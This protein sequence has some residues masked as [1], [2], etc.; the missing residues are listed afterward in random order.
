[1]SERKSAKTAAANNPSQA[2]LSPPP[3]SPQ[4]ESAHIDKLVSLTYDSNPDVRRRAALELSKIDDPRAVFALL[5]LGADKDP[6]VQDLARSSLNSFKGEE[7]ETLISL[8]KIFEAR[9][10]GRVPSEDM[11]AAKQ[12]LMPSLEKYFFSKHKGVREKLMPSLEKIFSWMPPESKGG[13][14]QISAAPAQQIPPLPPISSSKSHSHTSRQGFVDVATA[15]LSEEEKEDARSEEAASMRGQMPMRASPSGEDDD[16]SDESSDAVPASVPMEHT[17]ARDPLAGVDSIRSHSKRVLE[18]AEADVGVPAHLR[19]AEDLRRM[20]SGG[21]AN[22]SI[23]PSS[24]AM[25]QRME[26]ATNFPVPEYLQPKAPS[27]TAAIPSMVDEEKV[28]E[29]LSDEGV[30]MPRHALYYYK[31]AYAIAMTPGIKASEVKKEKE[32][33]IKDSKQDI[34]LAFKLAMERTATEGIESLSGLKP[35]MKKLST[36]P[37]EVLDNMVVSVPHGKRLLAYNRLLLSDGK[38]QLPLYVPPPRA[39]GIKPGDLLSLRDAFVDYWVK[40]NPAPGGQP[41]ELVL[42]LGKNGQLIVTK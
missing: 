28:E 13:S 3:S 31:L 5:E 25:Q 10:E 1:M 15:H 38:H 35:G 41:G 34:E 39:D 36:L 17:P 7:K 4:D 42:M 29:V 8:E 14:P 24:P 16:A 27:P 19:S 11:L 26:E 2:H 33:L 9:Q 18:Q 21:A 6:S 30:R 12:K 22:Q 37:L 32:R 20:R 40:Q 23:S